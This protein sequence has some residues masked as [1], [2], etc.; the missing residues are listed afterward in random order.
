LCV[1]VAGTQFT[2]PNNSGHLVAGVS[3]TSIAAPP[4]AKVPHY[5]QNG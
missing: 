4:T 5:C 2:Q 3:V 1:S